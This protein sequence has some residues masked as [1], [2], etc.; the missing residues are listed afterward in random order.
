MTEDIQKSN[1]Y[2]V[3]KPYFKEAM[4]LLAFNKNIDWLEDGMSLMSW[5]YKKVASISEVDPDK[6]YDKYKRWEGNKRAKVAGHRAIAIGDIVEIGDNIRVVTGSGW[7]KIPD[8]VWE[9]IKKN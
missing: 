8:V 2:F 3:K 5:E 6:I 9:K 4:M 1:I 7:M